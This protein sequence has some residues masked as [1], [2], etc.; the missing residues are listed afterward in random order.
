[1]GGEPGVL[2][3]NRT[4]QIS[5]ARP[6]RRQGIGQ[7]TG[8][9][10]SR[11]LLDGV[12]K[13]GILPG[14]KKV[15]HDGVGCLKEFTP[16]DPKLTADGTRWFHCRKCQR[17]ISIPARR[18]DDFLIVNKH[19]IDSP[20][21]YRGWMTRPKKGRVHVGAD[22]FPQIVPTKGDAQSLCSTGQIPVRVEVR[23]IK[24]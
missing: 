13:L 15:A 3:P 1:M 14:M 12:G 5:G 17:A 2:S 20:V 4:A 24:R 19:T 10:I 9:T 22:E 16:K 23:E 18:G 8:K 11:I 7:A 21:V 6:P